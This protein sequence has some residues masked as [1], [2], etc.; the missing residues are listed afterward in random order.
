MR[1]LVPGH[2]DLITDCAYD[3]YGARLATSSIDHTIKVFDRQNDGEW[4]QNDSWRAHDGA[5]VK[6]S[7]AR[8]Q[9][10][11]LLASASHDCTVKIWEEC[12]DEAPGSGRRWRP[13]H[14]MTD[15]KGPVYDVDFSPNSS[16]LKLAA[17]AADGVLRIY[18][19]LDP[20]NLHSWTQVT[21][22]PLLN[23]PVARQLQSSFSLSWAPSG[24]GTAFV[25]SVLE[26]AVIFR[27]DE[28]G[29]NYVRAGE[30]AQHRGLIRDIKWS[31]SIGR[32][33]SY[34][35]TACK[36][37]YVRIFCV[38]ENKAPS[39]VHES[40]DHEGEVW[41]VSWNATGTIL[42]SAGDDAKVR[43]WKRLYTGPFQ[44]MAVVNADERENEQ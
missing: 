8:P 24:K 43:F 1:A 37:G 28:T 20:N 11:Q 34:V 38:E 44:C 39:L 22:V 25:V 41:R 18:E 26:D 21:E 32:S 12:V 14:T 35:A 23:H 10:F 5:V 7:W 4:I 9:F 19:A 3:F 33:Y 42:A 6:L 29:K 31:P 36:D 13:C 27:L 40:A 16:S 30:L 17:I 2:Q 15:F